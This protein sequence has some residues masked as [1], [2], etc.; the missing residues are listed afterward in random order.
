[1]LEFKIIPTTCLGK[2]KL[3]LVLYSI[4]AEYGAAKGVW[5]GTKGLE[6][7]YIIA[8]TQDEA[9]NAIHDLNAFGKTTM[10]VTYTINA[11]LKR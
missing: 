1:M 10:S 2:P 4:Q 5:V 6:D 3:A 11:Y 9:I 7:A 8:S